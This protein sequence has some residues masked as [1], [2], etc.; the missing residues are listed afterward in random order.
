M[1]VSDA[2]LTGQAAGHLCAVDERHALH[3]LAARA[4][5]ALREEA[6]AAGFELAIAS[7]HRSFERQLA[8][9]NGK[10]R[11]E[12]PVHDDEGQPLARREMSRE[13]WVEAVLRFSALPGSS[14]H[15][16]GTDLDVYDAAA[17]APGASV[18]LVPAEVCAG[19]PFD[20]LHCWLDARMAEGLSQG[21]YRPYARDRGGVAPERWHL[22]FA[23]L[24]RYLE[25]RMTPALLR[26]SWQGVELEG[27]DV[28][29]S[30]LDDILSRYVRVPPRWWRA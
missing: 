12:R 8:I 27:R 1:S 21:F 6:A 10:L 3:P 30:A 5:L 18:Q 23:P 11:G 28:I 4:F 9:W 29:E 7:A 17:L 22:S 15:H 26:G 25:G 16:W 24:S 14:R 19:G 13:A 20:P 2:E